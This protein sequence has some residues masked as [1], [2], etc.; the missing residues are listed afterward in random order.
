MER[1]AI[2]LMALMIL[3]ACASLSNMQTGEVTPK[4]DF[5]IGLG[6]G[7]GVPMTYLN[8]LLQL[9]QIQNQ[10]PTDEEVMNI[11]RGGLTGILYPPV[12]TD[13]N[14]RYGIARHW[15]LGLKMSPSAMRLDGRYQI[16]DGKIVDLAVGLGLSFYHSPTEG[17][18]MS[19]SRYKRGDMDIPVILSFN[20]GDIFIPYVGIKWIGTRYD[21]DITFDPE[22]V[23]DDSDRITVTGKGN[24][25][26]LGGLLGFYLGY[27]W[28]YLVLEV[29]FFYAHISFDGGGTG[30]PHYFGGLEQSVDLVEDT[31]AGLIIYPA[32]GVLIIF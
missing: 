8:D 31:F 5:Q 21:M 10:N 14:F 22:E 25:N 3:A 28:I 24:A 11:V 32:V 2:G 13:L 18:T 19:M 7:V 17:E 23:A 1:I 29:T 16:L 27:K 20:L 12:V 30:G 26:L 6:L 9:Q 15:D 4:G